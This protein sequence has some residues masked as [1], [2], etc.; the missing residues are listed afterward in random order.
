PSKITKEIAPKSE[1]D[2]ETGS[3]EENDPLIIALSA[4]YDPVNFTVRR[5]VNFIPKILQGD[6]T[7]VTYRPAAGADMPGLQV[8]PAT[9]RVHESFWHSLP[10]PAGKIYVPPGTTYVIGIE[11]AKDGEV[12]ASTELVERVLR[13][14]L[15]IDGPGG[16]LYPIA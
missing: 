11:A 8:D 3:E 7:G 9:G 10:A 5:S 16:N 14:Q 6:A 12:V 1:A 4:F 2:T 13:D 15:T